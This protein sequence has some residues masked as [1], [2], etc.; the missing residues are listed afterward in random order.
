[1]APRRTQRSFW[2]LWYGSTTNVF[3]SEKNTI[4]DFGADFRLFRRPWPRSSLIFLAFSD[5]KGILSFLKEQKP[6][7]FTIFW[8]A[9]RLLPE[10]AAMSLRDL[11][12]SALTLL[13]TAAED[14]LSVAV[15][16]LPGL[17]LRAV[18]TPETVG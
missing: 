1:M 12:G 9:K 13:K 14:L 18:S 2:R 17:F 8:T 7:F 3:S 4:L 16:G 15:L 6:A 10:E 5:S 11:F